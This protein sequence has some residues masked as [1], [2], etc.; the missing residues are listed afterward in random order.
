MSQARIFIGDDAHAAWSTTARELSI[1]AEQLITSVGRFLLIDPDGAVAT[2]IR[3]NV[4]AIIR[5][6]LGAYAVRTDW[7]DQPLDDPDAE[8]MFAEDVREWDDE[9]DVDPNPSEPEDAIEEL[10]P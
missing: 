4:A 9:D 10:A 7:P 8:Q 1:T 6:P 3:E 5:E 2:T